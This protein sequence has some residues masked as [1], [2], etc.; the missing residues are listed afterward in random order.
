VDTSIIYS[1]FEAL[2]GGAMILDEDLRICFANSA[3]ESILADKNVPLAISATNTS[4]SG[5]PALIVAGR[6]KAARLRALVRSV[7]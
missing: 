7:V 4:A 2:P 5:R 6:E 1:A 3:A